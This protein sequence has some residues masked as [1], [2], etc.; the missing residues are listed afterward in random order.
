[1]NRR[2][3]TF[4]FSLRVSP[5]AAV[6]PFDWQVFLRGKGEQTRAFLSEFSAAADSDD[7]VDSSAPTS[8]AETSQDMI[9]V[10]T[11]TQQV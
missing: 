7:K 2:V 10:E 3:T 4:G 5:V 11:I 9:S 1:M 8:G 6:I